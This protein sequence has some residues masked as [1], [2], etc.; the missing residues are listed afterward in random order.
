MPLDMMAFQL[1][2]VPLDSFVARFPTVSAASIAY[3]QYYWL[4]IML[5][6]SSDVSISISHLL[7]G[8]RL[9]RPMSSWRSV[10][11]MKSYFASSL[12]IPFVWWCL[13]MLRKI[14]YECVR[15]SSFLIRP[16][17]HVSIA[18]SVG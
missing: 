9:Q 17:I 13:V 4:S 10:S 15:L 2:V 7:S 18:W 1:V 11:F 16:P 12:I 3:G 6:K 5:L 14:Y 8:R